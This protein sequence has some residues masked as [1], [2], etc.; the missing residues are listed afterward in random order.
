MKQPWLAFLLSF[1]FLSPAAAQELQTPFLDTPDIRHALSDVAERSLPSVVTI[2]S[3]K[4]LSMGSRRGGFENFFFRGGPQREFKQRGLGSGVIVDEKGYILT[5]N[6]VIEGADELRVRL[7]DGT[8][9]EAT[10]IG[11]DPRTDVA[12]IQ[13]KGKNLRPAPFGNSDSLRIAEF[14]LCVGSP[15]SEDLGHTVTQG[16][17]SATGR[18]SVGVTDYE[19]FIQ[20]DAAINPG[21]SGGPMLN[22]AGEIVGINTAIASRTGGFQGVGFAVP[23]NMARKVMNQLI[24]QGHVTRGWLGVVIQD[25]TRPLVEALSLES[26]KGVLVTER[27]S[28][29]PAAD[30]GILPGDV[31]THM[32]EEPLLSVQDLRNRVA[33]TAP[34]KNMRFK[35]L[36]EGVS[37]T[38]TVEIGELPE[39]ALSSNKGRT[40]TPK[41][42]S[43]TEGLERLGVAVERLTKDVR[44]RLGLDKR[45]KGVLVNSVKEGSLAERAGITEGDLLVEINRQVVQTPKKAND[46]LE[47]LSPGATLLFKVRRSGG[48]LFLAVRM[49]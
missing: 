34:G 46:I 22:L 40:K 32:G 2:L 4:T 47:K 45:T 18:N 29:S 38:V 11:T 41:A 13:V 49:E 12:V 31:L 39:P 19:D 9:L 15:L 7:H 17:V 28:G 23:S 27:M 14:V 37:K 36:R 3:T 5:N 43:K 20:T 6:H 35:L 30:A 44:N 8:E 26:R 21:N 16:I 48:A 24:E 1:S 25:L 10:V 42:R 33:Q